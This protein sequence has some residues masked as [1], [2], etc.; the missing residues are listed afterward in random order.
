MDMS[1]YHSQLLAINEM[2]EQCV[3]GTE[4]EEL[5]GL[6]QNIE[7]LL[8]LTNDNDNDSASEKEGTQ[9]EDEYSLFMAEMAKEGAVDLPSNSTEN[10]GTSKHKSY[11]YLEGKKFRAP[12]QHNW[13]QIVYHNAMICSVPD[14]TPS[15]NNFEVKILFLNPTHKEMLPCPYYFDLERDCSFS[16]DKCHYSHGELVPF[17][18]LQDYVEPKFELLTVGSAVLVKKTDNLWYRAKILN[19]SKKTCLVRFDSK[20]V[21]KDSEEIAFENLL[22]LEHSGSD[23]YSS[24]ESEEDDNIHVE[25]DQE[26]VINLSLMNVP[27]DQVL[28]D[29]EKYTKGIGS[30]LMQKMGYI[31]GAGLGKKGTGIVK[32]VT[33]LI[34]P[35]GKSLDY[36]MNL[37]E[38][39]NNPNLF[40]AEK[41]V[42]ALQRKMERKQKRLEK[43]TSEKKPKLNVCEFINST[44]EVSKSKKTREQ[45]L[46]IQQLKDTLKNGS[47]KEI[48]LTS[49]RIEENIKKQRITIEKLRRVLSNFSDQTSSQYENIHQKLQQSECDMNNLKNEALLVKNEMNRR[50]NNKEMA[51]F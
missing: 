25:N 45:E 9:I 48:H 19:I 13:G 33:A 12:H 43:K 22:P 26:D 46:S 10:A 44:I 23:H 38:Q 42:K 18:S 34:L 17:S 2:I 28:G 8:S 24:S 21:S 11:K 51:I 1:V 15:H 39:T 47:D 4:K 41:K 16:D 35:Q 31:V 30:K 32:P 29:W 36:C 37:K 49:F 27:D 50:K 20:N 7:E 5:I 3:D 6:K 14:E 40:S